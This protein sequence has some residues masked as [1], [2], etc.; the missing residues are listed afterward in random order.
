MK[1]LVLCQLMSPLLFT[2]LRRS[3]FGVGKLRQLAWQSSS[4]GV[5]ET[6]RNCV[7][8]AFMW[9]LVIEDIAKNI[10]ATLLRTQR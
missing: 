3:P 1:I 9:A 4:T 2:F 7:L 6:G 10:E 5:I 8:Q